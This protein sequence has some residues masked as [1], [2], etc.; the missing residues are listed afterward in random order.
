MFDAYD[1]ENHI[2]LI[3][4]TNSWGEKDA[5]KAPV[6]PGLLCVLKNRIYGFKINSHSWPFSLPRHGSIT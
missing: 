6:S 3:S 5:Q 1:E 2:T 4:L